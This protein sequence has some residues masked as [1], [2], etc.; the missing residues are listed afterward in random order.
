[1][2]RKLN[3]F[4]LAVFALS[5]STPM[6]AQNKKFKVVLDA[7]HG[8][9]DNGASYNSFIE[10]NIALSTTLKLGK[11]LEKVDDID[12]VYT[13]KTDVFVELN[14]RATIA[15]KAH[16]DLFMSI[17][18]NG[19]KNAPSAAGT[20]TFVM[21]VTKN[22]SN[23]EVARKENEVVTLEK[24]YKVKYDGYDPKSPQSV[25]GMSVQQEDNLINSIELAALIENN[26]NK[27]RK[28]SRGVKQAGF[29]VLRDIYMPRVLVELG[30][31]SNK[32]EGAYLNT[33]AGQ[34]EMATQIAKAILDYKK[35][36]FGGSAPDI[37]SIA[38]AA[39]TSEVIKTTAKDS[40]HTT[41]VV[42]KAVSSTSN[43]NSGVEFKIQI[44]ASG[45]RLALKKQNFKG[46]ED[47]TMEESGTLYKYF[48]GTTSDYNQ[49]KAALKEAKDKGFSSAY[50]VASKNGKKI[51]VTEALK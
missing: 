28:N 15:N 33:E 46:L 32:A 21:G 14:D 22:A 51:S 17:H 11:I 4:I 42:N 40:S 8:G 35:E 39:A 19:V 31:L 25:I 44:S 3:I 49:A 5:V 16:A 29:L 47:V 20:E 2:K 48:Y 12:V 26:F 1:M 36:Y 37:K 34:N 7:G 18:C 27:V 30:F 13:R 9:K 50:I 45:T 43:S 38:P 24:D 23:L 10:K 41:T 6:D